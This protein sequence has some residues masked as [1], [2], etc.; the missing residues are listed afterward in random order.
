M[1]KALKVVMIVWA[2]LGILLGLAYIFAPEQLGAMSGYA[3]GPAYVLYFLAMLGICYIVGSA[4]IIIAAQDPL[5]NILWVQFAIAGAIL[6]VIIEVYSLLRGFV[7]FEQVGT[8][9]IVDAV[10]AVALLALYPYRAARI[11]ARRRR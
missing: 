5:R 11:G 4:F 3:P 8:G 9:I 2:A 1:I 6:A 10:F 7:T